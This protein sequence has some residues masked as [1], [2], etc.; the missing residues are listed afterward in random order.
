[1]P[2]LERFSLLDESGGP[3]AYVCV[4]ATQEAEDF[5]RQANGNV[6]LI[7]EQASLAKVHH[8]EKRLQWLAARHAARQLMPP[9]VAVAITNNEFGK[10]ELAGADGHVSLSHT[11]GLAAALYSPR[12]AAGI[13][14]E[15]LGQ[16]RN[17]DSRRLFMNEQEQALFA[18][19]PNE[20]LFL[21]IWGAKECI[22]K[23][24]SHRERGLSFRHHM[25]VQFLNH[26]LT[27]LNAGTR[28]HLNATLHSAHHR[29]RL[30]I[31]CVI[32]ETYILTFACHDLGQA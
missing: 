18:A 4:W 9:G 10:P 6:L 5:F 14:I 22:Y 7:R 17:F 12:L 20:K 30:K 15:R 32:A 16:P 28:L 21:V 23:I 11:D 13:D 31:E 3:A 19:H 8:P 29:A 25:E 24:F 27:Q 1:M 2:L 26:D